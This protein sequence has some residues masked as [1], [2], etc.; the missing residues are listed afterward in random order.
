M[1]E[2]LIEIIGEAI[3]F[4]AD[5]A[6]DLVFPRRCPIC[7]EPLRPGKLIHP[8]CEKKMVPITRNYCLKC[9]RPIKD[10]EKEY[11]TDCE[12]K[13]RYFD[14]GRVAFEYSALSGAMYKFK[15]SHK[16]EYGECL[17]MMTAKALKKELR[18][19]NA[20]AIVPIPIHKNRKKTRGYNQAEILAKSI[21]KHAKIPVVTT[22]VK[23]VIDTP[24]LKDL[25]PAER[26]NCLKN[27]FKLTVDDVKLKKIILVDDIY[28]TG[29]TI[30]TVARLL[31][32]YGVR[33]VYFVTITAGNG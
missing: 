29:S 14:E 23:R 30:D 27:S 8:E 7:N 2:T 4:V 20:D 25:N 10:G 6:I 26:Q 18:L 33:S 22:L 3:G 21:G 16:P 28:T 15:Y 32:E 17:G 19:W 5:L 31:K 1:T 24:K 9:G 11:C 13:E 12:G